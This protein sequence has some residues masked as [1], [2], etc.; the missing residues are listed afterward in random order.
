MSPTDIGDGDCD[1]HRSEQHPVLDMNA[2]NVEPLGKHVQSPRR[3]AVRLP[4]TYHFLS[5]SLVDPEHESAQAARA[6]SSRGPRPFV[7]D[8]KAFF[9]KEYKKPRTTPGLLDQISDYL[10]P[11]DHWSAEL[12]VHARGKEIDVFLDMVGDEEAGG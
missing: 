1:N 2:E 6:A 11:C 7:K 3:R 12:V 10:V 4:D 5:H 9:A 8:M